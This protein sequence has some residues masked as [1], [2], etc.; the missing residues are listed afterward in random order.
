M[1]P[2]FSFHSTHTRFLLIFNGLPVSWDSLL[3]L[4]LA[5]CNLNVSNIIAK[6]DIISSP[7]NN[8][9][10]SSC[11]GV[12]DRGLSWSAIFD[13]FHYSNTY[14]YN[15]LINFNLVIKSLSE[16]IQVQNEQVDDVCGAEERDVTSRDDIAIVSLMSLSSLE[17]SALAL[18]GFRV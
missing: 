1:G 7:V 15:Y 13:H 8:R 10:A 16:K 4:L 11:V 5:D 2:V 6:L 3:L 17:S 14:N 18:T 9:G 12:G